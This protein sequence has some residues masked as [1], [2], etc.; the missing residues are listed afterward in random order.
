MNPLIWT[1]LLSLS[2]FGELRLSIP[3][4]LASGGNL[5][6]VYFT[7]VLGNIL[8]VPIARF[9]L[10]FVHEHLMKWKLYHWAFNKYLDRVRKKIEHKLDGWKYWVLLVFVAIPLPGTGAWS[11]TLIGWFFEFDKRKSFI[12]ISLG[13]M[14]A[15]LI[16]M[17]VSLGL[18]NGFKYF[19]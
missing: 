18:I 4:G 11:S 8:I 14:C 5:I 3:F 1:F 6:L 13:V 10:D 9:F 16:V 15:G 7:A 19:F 12:V 2:P 17:L